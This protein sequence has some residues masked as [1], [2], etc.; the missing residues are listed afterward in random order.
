MVSLT[1]LG[2]ASVVQH[3][4]R[5]QLD[6]DPVDR[7]DLAAREL[8]CEMH[9]EHP[10]VA[11]PRR[12]SQLHG[13]CPPRVGP[14]VEAALVGARV[15]PLAGLHARS[16][17]LQESFGVRPP[18]ERLAA[19]AAGGVRVPRLPLGS[20]RSLLDPAARVGIDRPCELRGL[21]EAHRLPPA[22]IQGPAVDLSW[23][24]P[25]SRIPKVRA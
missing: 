5:E 23:P 19:I 13:R 12:W 10:F 8:R 6:L 18:I 9:A 15:D 7:V 25:A 21:D 4:G 11:A 3:R 22:A 2:P 16:D 14:L 20:A 1:V 24:V 17:A